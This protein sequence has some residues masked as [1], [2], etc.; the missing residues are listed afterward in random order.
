VRSLE[1]EAEPSAELTHALIRKHSTPAL[2]AR[3]GMAGAP[4]ASVALNRPPGRRGARTNVGSLI[5]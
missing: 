4:A 1:S 3:L 5:P 2:R